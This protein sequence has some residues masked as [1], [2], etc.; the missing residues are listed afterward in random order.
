MSY[1]CIDE[2]LATH[3][4]ITGHAYEV[5]KESWQFEDDKTLMDDVK[6][7]HET[8]NIVREEV[9][10]V[11]PKAAEIMRLRAS[12][13]GQEE[14]SKVTGMSRS[15]VWCALKRNNMTTTR[16]GVVE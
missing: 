13:M 7:W 2:S 10:R 8:R 6:K 1:R 16:K 14:I 11:L 12:G 3:L 5:V 4:V 15:G 9:K